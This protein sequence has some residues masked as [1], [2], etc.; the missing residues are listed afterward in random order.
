MGV[1]DADRWLSMN[2]WKIAEAGLGVVIIGTTE[3]D[4]IAPILGVPLLLHAFGVL[5]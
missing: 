2:L 1:Y 5:K 4:P 3:F